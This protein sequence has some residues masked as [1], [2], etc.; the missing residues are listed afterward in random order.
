MY[1]NVF[2][3]IFDPSGYAYLARQTCLNL[4]KKAVTVK[5]Q[6]INNWPGAPLELSSEEMYVINEQIYNAMQYKRAAK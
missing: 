5:I 6:Q 1:V 2:A 4:Y 3:P